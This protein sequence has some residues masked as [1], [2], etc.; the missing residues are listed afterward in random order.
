MINQ[1][2]LDELKQCYLGEIL[3]KYSDKWS[4][5]LV[6]CKFEFGKIYLT[7]TSSD[8]M[9][10]FDN[11]EGNDIQIHLFNR[12][13]NYFIKLF[14]KLVT[15]ENS[16]IEILDKLKLYWI[17]KLPQ[18]SELFELRKRFTDKFEVHS[19]FELIPNQIT[20][21]KTNDFTHHTIMMEIVK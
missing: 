17:S 14:G 4:S 19:Y 5:P 12:N 15:M 11:F 21:W 8:N 6:L 13:S 10:H 7:P 16:Q 9:M 1:N 20:Y 2:V 3:F 18:F